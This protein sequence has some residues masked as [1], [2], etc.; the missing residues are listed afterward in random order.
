MGLKLVKLVTFT[1]IMVHGYSTMDMVQY[2]SIKN[3][4]SEIAHKFTEP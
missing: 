4:A 3:M 1:G 2:S